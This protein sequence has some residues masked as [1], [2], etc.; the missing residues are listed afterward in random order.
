[1][2]TI[3]FEESNLCFQFKK[4][5]L[6]IK[7]DETNFYTNRFNTLKGSKG[8]DFIV[9]N[10]ETIYLIEV[11]NFKGHE[12]ENKER[13]IANTEKSLALEVSHKVRDTISCLAG[14]YKS[15][16]EILTPYFTHFTKRSVEVK[17]ILFLEGKFVNQPLVFRAMADGMK[18]RLKWLTTKVF[19]ENVQLSKGR[20]YTIS[21][22]SKPS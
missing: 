4:G 10:D 13:L 3:S 2:T 8:V 9:L 18:N 19:V 15:G 20:I 14:A 21:R 1:M 11:K 7:F 5:L 12:I 6:P 16:N 17:V 22:L